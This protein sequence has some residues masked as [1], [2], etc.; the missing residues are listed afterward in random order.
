MFSSLKSNKYENE[1][2][3]F[4]KKNVCQLDILL[5][6]PDRLKKNWK[7]HKNSF[8]MNVTVNYEI[9]FQWNAKVE[10]YF[11]TLNCLFLNICLNVAGRQTDDVEWKLSSYPCHNSGRCK[12]V[13]WS[14]S[15]KAPQQITLIDVTK[16]R[17]YSRHGE[18]C[19]TRL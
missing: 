12:K 11:H 13:S 16:T 19:K 7:N 9:V 1:V 15:D 6:Y 5:A 10:I 8:T 4:I 2:Q 14:H 17:N 18:K 3:G